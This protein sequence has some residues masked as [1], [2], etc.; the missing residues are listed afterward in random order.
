MVGLFIGVAILA[1]IV[2]YFIAVHRS[3]G[4]SDSSDEVYRHTG[5]NGFSTSRDTDIPSTGKSGGYYSSKKKTDN[6]NN[7]SYYGGSSCSS[8]SGC[9]THSSC[10]SSSCSSGSSCGSGGS[11]GGGGCSG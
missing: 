3:G 6:N 9:S 10:S 4:D 11:C 7:N 2:I 1:V 8:G 5:G